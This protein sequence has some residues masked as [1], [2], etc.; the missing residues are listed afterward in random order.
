VLFLVGTNVQSGWVL[1]MCALLLGTVAAGAVL[2]RRMVKSIQVERRAPAEAFPGDEVRVDLV[3]TNP[4]RRPKV[5]LSIRDPHIASATAFVPWVGP[6]E[7]VTASTVRIA[8]RRGVTEGGSVEVASSAPFGVATARRSV[9]AS[10]RTVVFPRVVPADGFRM[11]GASRDGAEADHAAGR[12]PGHEVHGVRE[13]QR[14]D[15]LR[16]VHWPTTARHGALIVREF[17]R[18]RP[19]RLAVV[20]DTW[21]DAREPDA[22]EG[23]LD[24]CC[25]AAA[26][27][28]LEALRAGRRVSVAAARDGAVAAVP[29]A[30][31]R[32]VLTMLAE[33]QAPGGV[34][35]PDAVAS[36]AAALPG[37]AGLLLAFPTWKTNA[38]PSLLGAVG[39]L[40]SGGVDVAAVVV[41][42]STLH[43]KVPVLA[44]G[45]V[46]ELAWELAAAGAEVVLVRPG[47][48]L[49]CSL[50]GATAG[51]P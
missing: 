22:D 41:D 15:S 24:L 38:A 14:G 28:A 36:S 2:P 48:D 13:Y 10:G 21:A 20:V 18:E 37:S 46:D 8:S 43:P 35:F 32:E 5:S 7:T 25:T 40:A 31:R 3:V 30:D 45:E 33:L 49:A 23:A 1:V 17:E 34:S 27:V 42:A 50:A 16:H 29:D 9:A 51:V 6:G 47:D 26:S 19:A 12:G 39:E 4:G 11:L 44:V